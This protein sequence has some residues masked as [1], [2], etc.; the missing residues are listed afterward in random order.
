MRRATKSWVMKAILGL[1]ALTFV[2]FFGGAGGLGGFTG[3]GG[4]VGGVGNLNS[5]VQV[6]GIDIDARTVTDAYNQQLR[7]FS[8]LLGS[9]IGPDQARQLGLLD[10]TIQQLVSQALFD[11]TAAE[12]GVSISDQTVAQAVRALPQFQG[13]NGG[14][15]PNL[16]QATL[17]QAGIGEA[18]FVNSVRGNLARGQVLGT[19]QDAATAPFTMVDAI[20]NYRQE[21]RIV[22]TVRIGAI[23]LP[24]LSEPTDA[25]ISAFYEG[26]KDQFLA[27][28]YRQ[29]S[30]A[31]LSLEQLAEQLDVDEGELRIDYEI[32]ENEF[33]TP[34]LR[35]ITQAIFTDQEAA[36]RAKDMVTNGQDFA[37]AVEQVTGSPPLDLG[38]LTRVEILP[39]LA[40]AAFTLDSKAV[41]DP[42]ETPFGW[43]LLQI[44]RIIPENLPTFEQV[45]D[46]LAEDRALIMARDRIFEVM[47]AVTD[48][49]AGGAGLDEA[50]QENGLRL[51]TIAAVAADGSDPRGEPVTGLDPE[52]LMLRAA[53]STPVASDSD[54]VETPDG[55]FFVLR[56]TAITPPAPRPLADVREQVVAA[57]RTQKISEGAQALASRLV[58][59][60][61]GGQSLADAAAALDLVVELSEPVLRTG[62]GAQLPPA[63]IGI[64]FESQVAD[65]SISPDGE[66]VIVGRLA[67]IVPAAGA[68]AL[69]SLR[70]DLTRDVGLDIQAQL[71]AALQERYEVDINR[72]ALDGLF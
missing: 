33:R 47:D 34:E 17:S 23:D 1:L 13:A 37:A 44:S 60:A 5:L 58:D 39:E 70:N 21:R 30:V 45:R 68:T 67:E 57:W 24:N 41:G 42:I 55:G 14:F 4:G 22:E 32:R 15:D 3:G 53:F 20:Y 56:V 11:Q 43:H 66:G 16:Y 25:G 49:Y 62:E 51:R 46:R 72:A 29:F 9:Q 65:T 36:L 35:E 71:A 31:S 28:E 69:V 7:A 63:L 18:E 54:V 19:V 27:P 50:V 48:T 38:Q 59:N 52:G 61:A 10:Q 64:V 8:Q 12:L 26:A 2:A 6:G 40:A